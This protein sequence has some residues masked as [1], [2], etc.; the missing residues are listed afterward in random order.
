MFQLK[1]TANQKAQKDLAKA[2]MS[3]SFQELF[4]LNKGS[5]PVRLDVKLDKFDDCAKFERQLQRLLEAVRHQRAVGVPAGLARDDDVG[6]AGQR[7]EARRDRVPGLAA[8]DHRVAE[9]GALEERHV[10]RQLPQQVVVVADDAVA[11]HGRDERDLHT[12]TGALI[13]GWCW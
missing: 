9:R 11:R 5:I 4:N 8:H 13:A 6:A 10:L 7:P 3:P 12:A 2:I 1:D